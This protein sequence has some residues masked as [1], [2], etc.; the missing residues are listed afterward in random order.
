MTTTSNQSKARAVSAAKKRTFSPEAIARMKEKAQQRG[1][2]RSEAI[3]NK[4]RQA[5]EALTEKMRGSKDGR[6]PDGRE[7]T[8]AL[9]YELA[10]VH[11]TTL[12]KN[13]ERYGNLLAE[14]KGWKADLTE[15]K[16][17]REDARRSLAERANEGK[18]LYDRLLENFQ[19]VEL[20]LQQAEAERDQALRKLDAIRHENLQLQ[21]RLRAAEA[22]KVIQFPTERED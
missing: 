14:V 8:E 13:P 19:L 17:T 3:A 18:Q 7:L 2:A 15:K 21:E 4:V 9:L 1:V 6:L 10:G 5:K 22:L 12:S 11:W 20:E 16:P